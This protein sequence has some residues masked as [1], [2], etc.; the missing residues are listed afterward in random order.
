MS[1]KILKMGEKAIPNIIALGIGLILFDAFFYRESRWNTIFCISIL[2]VFMALVI[3]TQI[4]SIPIHIFAFMATLSLG[5][6]SLAIQ[7]I[8][9]IPDENAHLA[10]TEYLIEGH[11]FPEQDVQEFDTIASVRE[12]IANVEIPFDDSSIIGKEIDYTPD[13]FWHIATANISLLYFPQAI[14]MGLAKFLGLSVLWMMWLGRFSNLLT[15]CLLISLAIKI[16][17]D[18]KVMLLFVSLLPMS[19]QQAAS[20][21][22]DALINGGAIFTI[23]FFIYLYYKPFVSRNQLLL[24]FALC[25]F[26]TV[27]KVSNI[28]FGG[29]LLLIPRE[30]EDDRKKFWIKR[31]ILLFLVGISGCLYYY[32][33]CQFAPGLWNQEYITQNN[34]SSSEQIHYIFSNF[35]Y[36]IRTYAYSLINQ[37]PDYL[38]SLNNFGWLKIYCPILTV[39]MIF[40]FAKC[41]DYKKSSLAFWERWYI[42]ILVFGIYFLTSFAMYLG[43]TPVGATYTA[44][45]QGRYFIPALAL[46]GLIYINKPNCQIASTNE[47]NV[48]DKKYYIWAMIAMVCFYL[49]KI[50]GT[51][52]Y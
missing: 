15:Y 7:P 30:K 5:T 1:Q 38:L 45:V 11:L 35:S 50:T 48:F 36:W 39:V 18:L 47:S 31:L 51:Y 4:K 32:Y 3:I 10:R 27:S 20:F 24:F 29:L 13:K 43:W 52:Y 42:F 49:F 9:N 26:V 6:L 37:L 8:C 22:P 34:V 41:N 28:C 44:G 16:A 19:I 17:P 14:G 23:A 12:L 33:T 2:C 40:L 25:M 21:S 46:F